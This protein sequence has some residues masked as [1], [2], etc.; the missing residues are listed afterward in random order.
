MQAKDLQVD[1]PQSIGISSHDYVSFYRHHL[2]T[3]ATRFLHNQACYA[4]LKSNGR[5]ENNYKYEES[6][7]L[8]VPN[9]ANGSSSAN[10]LD[11]GLFLDFF[12]RLKNTGLVPTNLEAQVLEAGNCLFIPAGSIYAFQYTAF[13]FYRWADKAPQLIYILHTLM[14]RFPELPF[15]NLF[16]YVYQLVA[17]GVPG[18]RNWNEGHSF[19]YG[20]GNVYSGAGGWKNPLLPWVMRKFFN[21][22]TLREQANSGR[23]S[24]NQYVSTLLTAQLEEHKE[25]LR[26]TGIM[27]MFFSSPVQMLSETACAL[28]R[29]ESSAAK[30]LN[31]YLTTLTEEINKE[32]N[33]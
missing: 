15:E 6:D 23:H 33:K 10:V 7:V 27:S 9:R 8:C 21:T 24:T 22:K 32:K 5:G 1:V 25:R 31:P 28:T 20:S 4:S 19:V 12:S 17:N 16:L 11:P 13:C 18:N 3:Q 26:N 14:N 30:N 29:E 2:P